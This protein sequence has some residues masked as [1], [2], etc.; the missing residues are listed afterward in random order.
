MIP[1]SSTTITYG[2]CPWRSDTRTSTTALGCVSHLSLRIH[3]VILFRC[4][5][6]HCQNLQIPGNMQATKVLSLKRMDVIDM[7]VDACLRR[8]RRCDFVELLYLRML[9]GRQPVG[10]R[11][12][13][14]RPISSGLR[15]ISPWISN[16]PFPAYRGM[17]LWIL[18]HPFLRIS[19]YFLRIVGEPPTLI[20]N[21]PFFVFVAP[22][23]SHF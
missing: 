15:S 6:T 12:F 5:L 8:S 22:F 7:M 1:P 13:L 16:P 21:R 23:H 14:C 3:C 10:H 17:P 2:K 19:F 18:R 20:G 4:V 11:L 9:D